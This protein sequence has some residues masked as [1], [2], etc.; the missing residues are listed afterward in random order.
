M[1]QKHHF[2]FNSNICVDSSNDD[3]DGSGGGGGDVP[4]VPFEEFM[5]E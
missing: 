4:V 5:N 3:G 2:I 1:K